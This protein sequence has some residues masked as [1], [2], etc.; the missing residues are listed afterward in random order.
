MAVKLNFT[1]MDSFDP[2]SIVKQV[3]AL[4]SLQDSR[5]K[6]RDL[7]TTM[8]QSEDLEAQLEKILS[9]TAK[10]KQAA[11]EMGVNGS[12]NSTT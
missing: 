6:L 12:D 10:V 1:S 11:T 7:L 5:D 3:P 8:D 2:A 9:D 4:Q